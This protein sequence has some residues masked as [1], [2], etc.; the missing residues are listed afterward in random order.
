MFLKFLCK[1]V[2]WVSFSSGEDHVLVVLVFP[3]PR[4]ARRREGKR[5][6]FL[7]E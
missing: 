7:V 2:L 6:Y 4:V 5:R 1:G 3:G